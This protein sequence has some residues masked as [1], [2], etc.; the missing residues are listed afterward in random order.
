MENKTGPDLTR[1]PKELRLL[2]K[3]ISMESLEHLKQEDVYGIDWNLFI[4]LALHHRIYPLLYSK[5]Q[6]IETNVIPD[7]V[8]QIVSKICKQNTFQMLYLIREMEQIN[9]LGNDHDIPLLF[10]KG[11]VLAKELYG[12]ISLRTSSDLDILVPIQ[13]L[14]EL[15]ELLKKSGYVKD[16]YIE[17]VLNDW[18]WRHHHFTYIHPT[19][20]VKVEVH[21]RL[22]P[23][24]GKEPTFSELWDRKSTSMLTNRPLNYLG[25]EDLF[26]FLVSHGA[27]HGWS[28]LRWLFDI[29]Q[30]VNSQVN[31]DKVHILLRKNHYLHIGGQAILLTAQLL[32]TR[33]TDDMKFL[34]EGNRP[35]QLA[36]E[37]VFYLERMVNLHTDPIP[38]DVAK[39]HKHHLFSIM[40]IQQ[41]VLFLLSFLYPF[42]KD[43][44]TLPLPKQ[45][46]F[47]YFP[48]RPLLW[49]WRKRKIRKH[50]LH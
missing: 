44:E 4:E 23:G 1:L 49:A 3:F 14:G 37:A 33:V 36:D 9:Q 10:L 5:L 45:L 32:H 7:H 8:I 21:W 39:Y 38:E 6:K 30:I 27:R 47:L 46:H 20:E 35:K 28:R 43:A 19:K 40:S 26:L 42:P 41:K 29:H 31:W 22:N 2:I 12:D 50:A 48:L 24:P 25:K 18:K 17:T 15:E 13:K 34:I 11:P 16:E